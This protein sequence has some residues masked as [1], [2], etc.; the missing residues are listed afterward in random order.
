MTGTSGETSN[1]AVGKSAGSSITTGKSNTFIGGSA[2]NNT[3]DGNYNTAVGV[4]A[5]NS[6]CGNNNI[7]MGWRAGKSY[8]VDSGTFIGTESGN[9]I[10]TGTNN[11]AVGFQS[12][13]G[14]DSYTVTTGRIT[15]G[16]PTVTCGSSAIYLGDKVSAADGS[17]PSNTYVK[18]VNNTEGSNV[19]SFTLGDAQNGGT[20]VNATSGDGGSDIVLTFDPALTG[21]NNTSVGALAGKGMRDN[22][23]DNTL[24]GRRAGYAM[25]SRCN[26]NTIIGKEAGYAITHASDNTC[27]G[28]TAGYSITTGS[29]NTFIGMHSAY[30]LTT[31]TMNV[32]VGTYA[33]G[34]C[35]TSNSNVA[36][37]DNAG[38]LCTSAQNVFIGKGA[39]NAIVG[40]ADNVMIGMGSDGGSSNDKQIAIGL[41]AICAADEAIT[42]GTNIT[43]ST[44]RTVMFGDGGG[45]MKSDD[46][47]SSGAATWTRTSDKRKKRN[48]KDS[49]LGLEFINKL[50]PVSFQWKP[51]NEVPKEWQQYSETNSWN[52][53]NIHHGFIAQEVKEVL[54]EYNA[55]DSVAGWNQDDDGMQRLGETKLITPLIKAVQ[56]LSAQVEE[57]KSKLGE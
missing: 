53:D 19:T 42:I 47:D 48:I 23:N 41:T 40:G 28:S 11:T 37:G 33:L 2:G 46:W 14:A 55:P 29:T 21:A 54:D 39:G 16:S 9:Y 6:N 13:K 12:I 22:S 30:D 27:V 43:N 45:N 26:D 49:D 7:A 35:I 5:L 44:T 1:T 34:D 18:T 38:R 52:I 51:Q 4:R 15:S 20:D 50:R 3:D 17:I 10:T 8:T 36:V 25:L 31:G 57:L 56:E 24:L 32:A